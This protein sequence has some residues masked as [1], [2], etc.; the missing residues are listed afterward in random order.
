MLGSKEHY[1]ANESLANT[2]RSIGDGVITA[3]LDATI[4]FINPMGALLSGWSEEEAFGEKSCDL[5]DIADEDTKA[6]FKCPVMRVLETQE[7]TGYTNH[8]LLTCR[9]GSKRPICYN[10][11]PLRDQQG[12]MQ[13][14]VLVFHCAAK[15]M[16]VS[17][18][19]ERLQLIARATNDAVWDWDLA[20]NKIW[21]NSAFETL[22]GYE[23]AEEHSNPEWFFENIHPEDR[24]RVL[25]NIEEAREELRYWQ[26]EYRFKSQDGT[27]VIVHERG[28]V[29]RDPLEEP[30]RLVGAMMDITGRR[31]AQEELVRINAELELRIEERTSELRHANRELESFSYSVS[32]DLRSPLRNIN[33]LSRMLE[34]D[35]GHL[36][37][38]ESKENLQEL[39]RETNRMSSLIDD[40]LQYSRVGRTRIKAERLDIT[41]LVE[42]IVRELRRRTA[43]PQTEVIVHEN[44]TAE[45][46]PA[47]LTILY[48]NLIENALKFTSKT[49]QP[50]VEIGQVELRGEQVFFIK[51]NGAGFDMTHSARLFTPFERLHEEREFP[52]TGIG[53]ANV[54]RIVS[55]H[56]GR[57]WAEAEPGKGATFYFTL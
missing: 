15:R 34:Q 24:Q 16:Q 47:L 52:G 56:G 48:E 51:D 23:L 22:F 1:V 17:K 33:A 46:D 39:V 54:Y 30:V 35:S 29:M 32:H 42:G 21:W 18:S 53:L 26:E 40:M 31:Q 12:N 10:A 2:L 7:A 25:R 45:A 13:G 3:D 36:L 49:P 20:S 38:E 5:F 55:R 28:Y 50:R 9:D 14:V 43:N 27:Y 37:D 41:G 57:I 19:Q 4:T 6:K 11:A 44:M 8:T